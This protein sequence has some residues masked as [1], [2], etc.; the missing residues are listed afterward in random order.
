[1]EDGHRPHEH[2]ERML[3]KCAKPALEKESWNKCGKNTDVQK[4]QP[5]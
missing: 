1:M 3:D 5:F 4:P 2:G